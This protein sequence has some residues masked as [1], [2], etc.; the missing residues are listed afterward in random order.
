MSWHLLLDIAAGMIVI[1]ILLAG[2]Y[3]VIALVNLHI[4]FTQNI[5]LITTIV[6]GW[7]KNNQILGVTLAAIAS[8]AF[9]WLLLHFYLNV[10]P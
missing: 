6:R 10:G 2:I 5:P 7:I 8:F 9:F 3:E 4:P 1:A